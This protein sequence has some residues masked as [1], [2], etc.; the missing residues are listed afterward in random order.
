M[1]I[2][3]TF[4]LT[5]I[6]FL[7]L[8]RASVSSTDTLFPAESDTVWITNLYMILIVAFKSAHLL[9]KI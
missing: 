6:C 3:N 8:D 2:K 4:D 1:F 7:D 5:Y 9:N